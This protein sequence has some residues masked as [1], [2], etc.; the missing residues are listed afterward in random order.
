VVRI[1]ADYYEIVGHKIRT[2]I[3]NMWQVYT[4][5]NAVLHTLPMGDVN[6]TYVNGENRIPFSIL[7]YD[8]VSSS[9]KSSN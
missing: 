3:P 9:K 6:L 8:N 1:D 4:D 5:N 2:A 7:I